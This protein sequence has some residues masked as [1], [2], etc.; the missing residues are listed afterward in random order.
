MRMSGVSGAESHLLQLTAALH[1]YSGWLSDVVIPSPCPGA[2]SGFAEKL[3]AWSE[4]VE[5]IP[6]RRDVSPRLVLRLY[7]LLA[8][9]RYD[10]AHAHLVHAD[11]YL[12]AASLVGGDVPLITSKHNPDPFRRLAAFRL[13][14]RAC[15]RRYSAA[16]AISESLR[17]FTEASTGVRTVTVH[18]GLAVGPG[19]VPVHHGQRQTTRLLAVGRLDEQKGFDV[20]IDAMK[21]VARTTP[22]THLSIAGDGRQRQLLAERI[23]A[24]GL[25]AA[26]SLLGTRDDVQELMLNADIL[27]HPARWEGFGLVL[28]EAMRA[29]LP[30]VATSAAA[31]PEVVTDGLTGILVPPDDPDQLAAAIIE[32]IQNPTQRRKMGAAGFERLKNFFSPEQM[33]KGVAAVYDAALQQHGTARV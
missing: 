3:T 17:E 7:R 16:I 25:G 15:L 1:S 18:Y 26:V 22:R 27:V 8:S 24:L 31:I 2:L 12:A 30:I 6:M 4:R 32:L 10:I 21:L 9:G 20:A 11:W 5:V 33:A 19:Q 28:L 14:E 13:V 29:G 23:T